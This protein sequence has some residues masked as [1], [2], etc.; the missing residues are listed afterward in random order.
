LELV[1]DYVPPTPRLLDGNQVET[2]IKLGDKSLGLDD[3][4][5]LQDYNPASQRLV[6][7][8]VQDVII[9]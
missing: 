6:A 8:Y 1:D 5:Y 7:D 3:S 2:K 4:S 9:E